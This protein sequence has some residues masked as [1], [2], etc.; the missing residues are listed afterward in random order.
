M[1]FRYSSRPC[2]GGAVGMFDKGSDLLSTLSK[3]APAKR[4]DVYGK[5]NNGIDV[6]QRIGE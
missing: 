5:G 1:L 6:S 2:T 3:I 4:L